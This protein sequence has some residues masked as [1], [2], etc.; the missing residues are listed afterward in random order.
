MHADSDVV[1]GLDGGH[2]AV[3]S[4]HLNRLRLQLHVDSHETQAWATLCVL[5]ALHEALAAVPGLVSLG[6]GL[7]PRTILD[8]LGL[9]LLSQ[10]AP[11]LQDDALAVA[12]KGQ[13]GLVEAGVGLSDLSVPHSALLDGC[14]TAL[15]SYEQ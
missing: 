12:G 13:V 1:T 4:Q 7:G 6:E 5:C 3:Q 11:F 15:G 9:A 14:V 10:N 8:H 2:E